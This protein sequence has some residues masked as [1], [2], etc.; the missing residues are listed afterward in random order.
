MPT[1][2]PRD[3]CQHEGQY[4]LAREVIVVLVRNQESLAFADNLARK[5][6][7]KIL[8]APIIYS[9]KISHS[10]LAIGIAARRRGWAAPHG[11][12]SSD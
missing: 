12:W 8:F 10:T 9:A 5:C 6:R 3:T 2:G 4:Y 1:T 11:G 7:T